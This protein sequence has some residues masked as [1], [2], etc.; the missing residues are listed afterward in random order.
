MRRMRVQG[1]AKD[2]PNDTGRGTNKEKKITTARGARTL[3]LTRPP[4]PRKTAHTF[5]RWCL[6]LPLIDVTVG[7]KQRGGWSN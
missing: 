3:R 4:L 7:S 2:R 5:M 6:V 1:R